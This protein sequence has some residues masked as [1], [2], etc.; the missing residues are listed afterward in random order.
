MLPIVPRHL[1]VEGDST[2]PVRYENPNLL[3][4]LPADRRG[5]TG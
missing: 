5:S 2:R 1:A 3:A 4:V